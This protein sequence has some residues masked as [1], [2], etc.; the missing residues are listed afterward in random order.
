M[1]AAKATTLRQMRGDISE[2][3]DVESSDSTS[4]SEA[5][6][7]SDESDTD[8]STSYNISSDIPRWRRNMR[9]LLPSNDC[10]KSDLTNESLG[11]E[12]LAPYEYFCMILNPSIIDHITYQ[13]NLY[14]H[15]QCNSSN[16]NCTSE[17]MNKFLGLLILMGVAKFPN[18]RM[19][20]SSDM[21]YD[22]VSDTM[23]L[24]RFE[25]IKRNFH[26]NDNSFLKERDNDEYDPLFKIRPLLDHIRE[27]CRKIENEGVQCVDEQMVRFRGRSHMKQYMPNK[28]TKYGYKVYARCSKSGIVHDFHIQGEKWAKPNDSIGFCGDIVLHLCKSLP[29]NEYFV[30]YCDRFYTSL[31]LIRSLKNRNVFTVGTVNANRLKQCH[32]KTDKEME[33]GEADLLVDANSGTCAIKWMD[34][35][36]VTFATNFAA[37]EPVDTCRRYDKKSK[38]HIEVQ[39]PAVVKAYN[40]NMGGVDIHDMLKTLYEIDHK[41]K[42]SYMRIVY[43]LLSV[44]LVNGW[45]LMRR[46]SKKLDVSERE[47]P[48]LLEFSLKVSKSLR[49]VNFSGYRKRGR[50]SSNTLNE[51]DENVETETKRRKPT[52]IPDE[53]MRRDLANH[54]PLHTTKGRCRFCKVGYSRI[55]CEKCKVKLC[56]NA[57]NNCFKS[58]HL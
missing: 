1:R 30:L 6:K 4:D 29:S 53:L 42:K 46:H 15:Q 9:P 20:W 32:F 14:S 3:S 13:T 48:K 44:S 10:V 12:L 8:P 5:D 35:K 58:F 22:E 24:K 25:L 57:K 11:D 52:R 2:A 23:S 33:R 47:I 37:V 34:K 26:V 49:K 56:L 50:P 55:E 51:N 39:R 41:S 31:A 7:N 45:L 27:N 54:F 28:P 21:G 38:R 36:S 43:F 40:S 17:E 18:F 19:Y 16:L